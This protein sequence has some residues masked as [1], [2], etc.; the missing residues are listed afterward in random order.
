MRAGQFRDHLNATIPGTYGTIPHT[1]RHLVGT[2]EDYFSVLTGEPPSDPLPDRSNGPVSLDDLA[3]RIRRLVPRWE[4]LAGDLELQGRKVTFPD[5]ISWPGAVLMEQAI[6]HADD[7]RTH[8]LSILGAR[9]LDVPRLDLWAHSQSACRPPTIAR[10]SQ[11]AI[12]TLRCEPRTKPRV[13]CVRPQR[14]GRPAG[15]QRLPGNSSLR[16]I[17]RASAGGKAQ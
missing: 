11:P 12:R 10:P 4:I 5:G 3:E 7:H 16:A 2:E 9:G 1:L 6:R 15:P 8:V 13:R 14:S 17:R